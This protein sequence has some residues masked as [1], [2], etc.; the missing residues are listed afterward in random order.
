MGKYDRDPRTAERDAEA[1]ELRSRSLTY[2]QIAARLGISKAEAH[3]AVARV[4][5][6][7]VAE[8]GEHARALELQKLDRAE[9]A[10]LAVLERSHVTV[11]HGRIIRD[12]NEDPLLDDG[13]ILQ[14]AGMLARL[15]ES[16]RKLIGLDAPAQVITEGRVRYEV[17]GVDPADLT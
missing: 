5:A 3:R 17:V 2:S 1:A 15:S 10:V 7:T 11:S 14:A 8:A 16:R 9:A 4:L 12:E 6:E 13:P